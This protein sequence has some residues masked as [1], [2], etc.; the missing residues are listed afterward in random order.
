MEG[1]GHQGY[2]ESINKWDTVLGGL[3]FVLLLYFIRIIIKTMFFYKYF[4]DVSK[5]PK[6]VCSPHLDQWVAVMHPLLFSKRR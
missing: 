6:T 3:L 4:I 2:R 5:D 1:V